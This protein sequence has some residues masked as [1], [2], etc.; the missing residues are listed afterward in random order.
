MRWLAALLLSLVSLTPAVAGVQFC[1]DFKVPVRFAVAYQTEKGWV[2]EGW[3]SVDPKKCIVDPRF[4]G[5]TGL[6]WTAE[7]A[8]YT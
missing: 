5:L 7:S 8:P 2:T 1:S 4:D 3:V 6:R